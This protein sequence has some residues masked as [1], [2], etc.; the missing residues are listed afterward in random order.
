MSNG[1]KIGHISGIDPG[2]EFHRRVQV[3]R[4]NLHRDTVRGISWLADEVDGIDVADAIVLHGGYED[5]EDHWTW[6][7]YTGASPDVDKYKENGVPKLRRSQSWTYQDN[8]AL[9]RSFERGHPVRVIRGWKGDSRY[10]PIDCYRYDGLYRITKIRTAASKSPAPDGAP[11]EICQFDLKRLPEQL[12]DS[13]TIE[14]QIKDLLEQ[15]EGHPLN[16]LEPVEDEAEAESD[17]ATPPGVKFPETRSTSVQRLVRDAAV[18]RNVKA[19]YDGTCQLCGLRI[20]GPNGKT[21]SEGAHIQPL[22]EPHRGPDV[23]PNV[24]CLC[25]NCHVRLDIGAIV[26][27]DDWSIIVRA[28]ALGGNVHPKLA[29][30]RKHKVHIDYVR[31]HRK[32]WQGDSDSS[33]D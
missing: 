21:Y 29:M 30:H 8:A 18:P 17:E 25:P 20:V 4:A 7:R 3:K 14:H 1:R 6:V 23:E 11:I 31:Y 27:Q 12:Q 26:I 13:T 28:G 15:Q 22:G 24:L 33:A 32:R 2:A 9:K 5:D 16:E 10:S 19:L